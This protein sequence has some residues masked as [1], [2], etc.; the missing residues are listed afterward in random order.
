MAHFC[1]GFVVV[2]RAD[3]PFDCGGEDEVGE[4]VCGEEGSEEG[5]AVGCEDED[6]FYWGGGVG[7]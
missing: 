6:F 5:A 4:L 7:G 3:D 2:G 1:A